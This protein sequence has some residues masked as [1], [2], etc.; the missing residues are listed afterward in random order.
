[1]PLYRAQY[2]FQAL[3]GGTSSQSWWVD[4][5]AFPDGAPNG[6]IDRLAQKFL[7]LIT[8]RWFLSFVR[9][10]PVGKFRLNRLFR[11]G[12]TT[13]KGQF[14]GTATAPEVAV[15]FSYPD[16]A[17]LSPPSIKYL[18]GISDNWLD[19]NGGFRVGVGCLPA[20]QKLNATLV[21]DKWGWLGQ[22]VRRQG[23][24]ATVTSVAVQNT[25]QITTQA[26]LFVAPNPPGTF[27]F[28]ASVFVSGVRGAAIVNRKLA[29]RVIDASTCITLKPYPIL[30]YTGG[31]KITQSQL[32]LVQPP[33]GLPVGGAY[34]IGSH[35]VGRDFF[36][37]RGRRSAEKVA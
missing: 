4:S 10:S 37:D 27:P 11:Y 3:I 2:G 5:S 26:P 29:V 8:P 34:D 15:Q 14:P 13:G 32:A 33:D 12:S 31:G 28:N 20:A 7:G 18:H 1:M 21:A 24:V 9:V 17:G 25:V 19:I 36:S 16:A 22:T 23:L 6:I 30:P 35:K